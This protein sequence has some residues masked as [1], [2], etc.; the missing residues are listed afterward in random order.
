M[1]GCETM[2][3]CKRNIEINRYVIESGNLPENFNGYKIAQVSDLHNVQMGAN[4]RRLLSALRDLKPDI[5]AITGDLIDSRKTDMATSLA[6]VK[7][8]MQIA[9]CFFVAGN[10]E[11][12]IPEYPTFKKALAE[13][14][15]V[16]LGNA[17]YEI[18]RGD[19]HII[20]L[21]LDDP[22]FTEGYAH[23]IAGEITCN[24][25]SKLPQ[26]DGYCILLIHRPEPFE[27][28][29]QRKI[30]LVLSGHTHGGQIRLPFIA[31]KATPSRRWFTKCGAGLFS[32]NGTDMIVS[33]GIGTSVLPIRINSNPEVILIE[34]SNTD[35]QK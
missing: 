17:A 32:Q 6:F 18:T 12:R 23:E 8:A 30:D 22:G 31:D 16:V 2:K 29:V 27:A 3:I 9:P 1:T 20:F 35:S 24:N 15:V 19:E 25:L 28:F 7:E 4:N 5:I 26:K 21:G 33:R 34:L 13:A 14:G 11:S 10:H